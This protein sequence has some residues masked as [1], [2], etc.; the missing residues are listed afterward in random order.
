VYPGI[1]DRSIAS[2]AARFAGASRLWHIARMR[3]PLLLLAGLAL[4]SGT[5]A[6]AYWK[7]RPV[8]PPP[9]AP[10]EKSLDDIKR[11]DMAKWLEDLGYNDNGTASSN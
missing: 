5:G 11:D 10:A 8:P 3:K 9:E 4:L 7:L 6:F 2:L 1:A